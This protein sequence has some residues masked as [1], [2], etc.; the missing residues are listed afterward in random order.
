MKPKYVFND[1][2]QTT[3]PQKMIWTLEG[4][5]LAPTSALPSFTALLCFRVKNTPLPV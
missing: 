3:Y 5:K 4:A 1:E 2:N